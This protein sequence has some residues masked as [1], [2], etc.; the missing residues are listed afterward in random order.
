L[1]LGFFL[2][3]PNP[4]TIIFVA[5]E[6]VHIGGD[7][8]FPECYKQCVIVVILIACRSFGICRMADIQTRFPNMN[9]DWSNSWLT[10][11]VQK[12]MDFVVDL[13]RKARKRVIVWVRV[14]NKVVK[15][16][17]RRCC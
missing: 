1:L 9:N 12:T 16:I 2:H 15:W 4:L 13:A 14:C 8:V 17:A 10:V 11:V 5:D 3:A 7:E 6:Y